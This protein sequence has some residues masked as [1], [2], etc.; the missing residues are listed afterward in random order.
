MTGLSN[1]I[2]V[3]L[4]RY[5]V[6]FD[7]PHPTRQVGDTIRMETPIEQVAGHRRMNSHSR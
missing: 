7:L 4:D 5:L 2:R 6:E 1:E 3:H